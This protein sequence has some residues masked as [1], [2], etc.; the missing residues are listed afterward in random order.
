MGKII[1]RKFLIDHLPANKR[2][3]LLRYQNRAAV[4]AVIA[5]FDSILITIPIN[6][7]AMDPF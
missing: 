6:V 2:D 5:S 1:E 7:L 4:E 3:V